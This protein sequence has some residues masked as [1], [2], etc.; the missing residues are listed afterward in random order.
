MQLNDLLA[1]FSEIALQLG[2]PSEKAEVAGKQCFNS[3][4]RMAEKHAKETDR[5]L[6]KCRMEVVRR[7]APDV[8]LLDWLNSL[9]A[10]T[11]DASIA[12]NVRP[13]VPLYENEMPDQEADVA[14]ELEGTYS[15]R[16]VKITDGL[17]VQRINREGETVQH[18]MTKLSTVVQVGDVVD[19]QY[20]G[21]QGVVS[22]IGKSAG[23][24]R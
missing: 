20:R 9:P 15:G 4:A 12:N 5:D 8:A 24:E 1:R 6:R 10:A 19:I 21:G 23:V 11:R 2:V 3:M 22:G 16:V 18:D 14:V 17:A 7:P 13:Y